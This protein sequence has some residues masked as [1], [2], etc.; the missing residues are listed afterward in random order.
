MILVDTKSRLA[1]V[2]GRRSL[3]KL[4]GEF[5]WLIGPWGPVLVP[6]HKYPKTGIK[7]IY[8]KTSVRVCAPIQMI[9]LHFRVLMAW[10]K[11]AN[12]SYLCDA[13]LANVTVG[14]RIVEG[15]YLRAWCARPTCG[16]VPVRQ[17]IC[18][19]SGT[20][21]FPSTDSLPRLSHGMLLSSING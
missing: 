4:G 17:W 16:T 14:A 6:G 8:G 18:L 5:A 2:E 9:P 3:G 19:S 13:K 12:V 20:T 10:D 1:V 21:T 15:H 7:E 11:Y